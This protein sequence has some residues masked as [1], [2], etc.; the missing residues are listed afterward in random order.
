MFIIIAYNSGKSLIIYLI[1][2]FN[3]LRL[4]GSKRD[5]VLIIVLTTSLVNSYLKIS[6]TM[7]IIVKEMYTE[8]IVVMKEKQIRE[9]LYLHGNQ[10]TKCQRN[11]L[12]NMV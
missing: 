8:F 6:K 4:K 2:I 1:L 7:D 5:K 10:Y 11:G 12:N 9:L 3:L